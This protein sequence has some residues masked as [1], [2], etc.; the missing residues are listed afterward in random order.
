[1]LPLLAH[2]STIRLFFPG[3]F[4]LIFFRFCLAFMSTHRVSPSATPHGSHLTSTSKKPHLGPRTDSR[5]TSTPSS[6][7]REPRVNHTSLC[8]LNISSE[9]LNDFFNIEVG[10]LLTVVRHELRAHELY[11]LDP[12]LR[13]EAYAEISTCLEPSSHSLNHLPPYNSDTSHRR[14]VGNLSEYRWYLTS[15]DRVLRPLL[16]YFSVLTRHAHD[17]RQADAALLSINFMLYTAHLATLAVQYEWDAVMRYHMISF[18]RRRE[19]MLR[20]DFTGWARRDRED[21]DL[22]ELFLFGHEKGGIVEK[23]EWEDDEDE[24]VENYSE[25]SEDPLS[26]GEEEAGEEFAKEMVVSVRDSTEPLTPTMRQNSNSSGTSS[27]TAADTDPVDDNT[28]RMH[29]P[30]V[31]RC[32]RGEHGR[33]VISASDA[34]RELRLLNQA[35]GQEGFFVTA[36]GDGTDWISYERSFLPGEEG[37]QLWRAG[38]SRVPEASFTSRVIPRSRAVSAVQSEASN[39]NSDSVF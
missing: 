38:D 12:D 29:S 7:P 30:T 15:P 21:V 22:M 10:T 1:M 27:L 34:V 18:N 35:Y 26:V 28:P 19:E 8:S 11:K 20:G 36:D 2:S 23:S 31:N 3:F 25:C 32:E 24:I 9:L 16:L 33:P 6:L 37:H 17:V 13:E 14:D 39:T 5:S 4:L